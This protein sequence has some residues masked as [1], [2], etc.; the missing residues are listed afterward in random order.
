[1]AR[2][3]TYLNFATQTEEVEAPEKLTTVGRYKLT[4]FRRSKLT[5]LRRSKLTTETKKKKL[6]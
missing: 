5:T 6:M 4:M 2:V 3:S 1:M